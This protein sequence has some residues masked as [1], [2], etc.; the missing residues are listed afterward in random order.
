MKRAADVLATHSLYK[1][2]FT[3]ASKYSDANVQISVVRTKEIKTLERNILW[4][5]KSAQL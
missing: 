2:A 5:I 3:M 4:N 1:Q